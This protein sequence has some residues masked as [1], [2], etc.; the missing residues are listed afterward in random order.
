MSA[1]IV[2]MASQDQKTSTNAVVGS[3]YSQ[4]ASVSVSDVDITIEFVYIS[5]RDKKEEVVVRVT[6]P[7]N[8]GQELAK[9]I[10][11]TIHFHEAKKKNK[12]YD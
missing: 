12:K 8:S 10:L 4:A 2:C 1:I 11:N 7:R 5:P 9:T 6:L 3:T